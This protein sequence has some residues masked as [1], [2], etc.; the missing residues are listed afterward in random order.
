M[1]L[2]RVILKISLVLSI[3]PLASIGMEP[4][5]PKKGKL[6]VICGSMFSGKSTEL[7][8]RLTI[9]QFSKKHIQAFKHSFDT[10]IDTTHINSHDHATF[11]AL[12]VPNSAQ[13]FAQLDPHAH[14]YGIDEIQFFDPDIIE[15]LLDLV[16][17]RGK[18]VIVAGLDLNFRA[19]PF[20]CIPFLLA[21]AN[22]ITKLNARCFRCG[23][24]AYV[25]QRL[26]DGNPAKK[27]D[28][29]ILV[30]AKEAYEAR[31]RQCYQEPK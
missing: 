16:N 4:L 20:P 13:F 6:E 3:L 1:N 11:P 30:G 10:R 21:Y 14:V 15:I 31:C 27:S 5:T 8:R 18:H 24:K 17:K 23:K 19:E 2:V 26:V 9:A 28:P 7:I 25:S 12:A 22:N 29:L